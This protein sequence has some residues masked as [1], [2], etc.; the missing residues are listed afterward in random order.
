MCKLT[1][2]VRTIRSMS[3]VLERE[4]PEERR[5][6]NVHANTGPIYMWLVRTALCCA[7]LWWL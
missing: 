4:R 6:E 3:F 2:H 1:D 7:V 5:K